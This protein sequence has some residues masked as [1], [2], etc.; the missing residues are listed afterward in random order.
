MGS[1]FGFG[2]SILSDVTCVSAHDSQPTLCQSYWI[3]SIPRETC[4][5]D[6]FSLHGE[7]YQDLVQGNLST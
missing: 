7:T 3:S 1:D 5:G 6:I 2:T 4:L